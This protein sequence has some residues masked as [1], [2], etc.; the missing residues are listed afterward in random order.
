MNRT[1]HSDSRA[2]DALVSGAYWAPGILTTFG[3][4][5]LN[6]IS[7]EAVTEDGQFGDGVVVCARVWT[8]SSLILLFSGLGI[9]IWCMVDAYVTPHSWTAGGLCTFLQN[10]LI[11]IA[12]F[13]FRFVRRSGEN[14][15]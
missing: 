14:A 11:L 10:L 9:S 6:A 12:A 15:I 1:V 4:V 13:V 2:P 8:M 3:L 5:G 7:W